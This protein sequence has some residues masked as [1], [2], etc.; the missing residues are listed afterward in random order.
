MATITVDSA[1]TPNILEQG[2]KLTIDTIKEFFQRYIST[3]APYFDTAIFNVL[4]NNLIDYYYSDAYGTTTDLNLNIPFE[5]KE[6]FETFDTTS[7]ETFDKILVALGLPENVIQ[8]MSSNNKFIFLKSLADFEQYKGTLEFVQKLCLTYSEVDRVNI[9]EL[10]IDYNPDRSFPDSQWVFKPI[11]IYQW[12]SS[13][14]ELPILMEEIDYMEVYNSVPSLLIHTDDLDRMRNNEELILPIKSNILLVEYNL[15]RILRL[16]YDLFTV[17]YLNKLLDENVDL[18]FS[19]AGSNLTASLKEV[20]LSWYYLIM[21]YADAPYPAISPGLLDFCLNFS[22]S[23]PVSFHYDFDNLPGLRDEYVNL[24]AKDSAGRIIIPSKED[25][26]DPTNPANNPA[27]RDQFLEQDF[28]NIF[29]KKKESS[30][31]LTV[32]DIFEMINS[33]NSTLADYLDERILSKDNEEEQK[34]EINKIL[35]EIYYSLQRFNADIAAR[36]GTSTLEFQEGFTLASNAF[37]N[38]L[39]QS[40]VSPKDTVTYLI[41]SNLKPYHVELFTRYSSGIVCDDIFDSI[42]MK[43]PSKPNFIFSIKPFVSVFNSSDIFN[44]MTRYSSPDDVVTLSTIASVSD[45]IVRTRDLERISIL[46]L[47][48]N[49]SIIGGHPTPP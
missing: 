30:S 32:L 35:L 19:T 33:L 2:K 16:L 26:S 7:E 10:Y 17:T 24:E 46:N 36:Y 12:K 22:Y 38:S 1:E 28:I 47:S 39:S 5:L 27:I 48:D 13:G 40:I 20:Y 21:R 11:N 4:I 23:D 49:F 8:E 15:V 44:L 41:L 9:Y 34:L 31:E 3:Y 14:S 37:M 29:A 18:L 6:L 42:W 45:I 25:A 43:E